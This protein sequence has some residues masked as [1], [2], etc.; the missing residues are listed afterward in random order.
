MGKK[1]VEDAIINVVINGEKAISSFREL[2]KLRKEQA[3]LVESLNKNSP[4]Y[5]Q[6][7][8]RLEDLNAAHK[9]WRAE[10]NNST[11]AIDRMNKEMGETGKN[12]FFD[13]MKNMFGKES[14][15]V[16]GGNLIA[17]GISTALNVVSSFVNGSE[18]AYVE[19][20]K[21]QAQLDA[22]LK[23]T[24]GVAGQTTESLADM[25]EAL[26]LQTGIDDDVISKGEQMLLTFTNVRGTIYEQALPAIV[27]M[28]AAMNQGTVTM[29]GI[30]SASIQVGKALNDPIKGMTA[31]SKVGVTFD[32]QQKEHIETLVKSNRIMDA[33]A[34]ILKELNKEFGGV[35]KGMADTDVGIGQKFETRMGNIQEIIG[36]WITQGKVFLIEFAEPVIAWIEKVIKFFDES[37][38]KTERFKK[39]ASDIGRLFGDL[40]KIIEPLGRAIGEAFT[41]TAALDVFRG[42]LLSIVIPLKTIALVISDIRK[43]E[44]GKAFVD[45]VQGMA[46][47]QKNVANTA[48]NTLILGKDIVV[49]VV[50][51][52]DEI[53]KNLEKLDKKGKEI[54]TKATGKGNKPLVVVVPPTTGELTEEQKLA[55]A[56]KA[57]QAREKAAK[58]L[59]QYRQNLKDAHAE[60]DK[61]MADSAKG[62]AK[63]LDAQ[64]QVI[65]DKYQK[66]IDRLKQLGNDKNATKEDKAYNKKAIKG[67]ETERDV[68]QEG[69]KRE[70]SYSAF[71]QG[72]NE[73][74]DNQLN[75]NKNALADQL[76]NEEEFAANEFEIE[77][78]RLTDLFDLRTLFGM[79]TLDLESKLADGRVKSEKRAFDAHME[80]LKKE[81]KTEE[82]YLETRRAIEAEKS[83]LAN[84]GLQLL[85]SVFG[86]SKGLM[87]AQLAVE[88]AIAISKIVQATGVEIAGYYAHP[89]SILSL[90][91][92][93]SILAAAAK[94]RAGLSIANIVASGLVEGIGISQSDSGKK[95]AKGG[96]LP[97]G[98]GH[99]EGGLK[100]V[101]PY[102]M[103]YGEVE[104]GEPILS[105]S[106]YANN[107]SLVDALLNSNGRQLNMERI[108][109]AT[110]SRERRMSNLPDTIN[111]ANATVRDE[112][113]SRST[114][115][116]NTI[117]DA[118]LKKMDIMAANM[119]DQKIVLS[120]RIFE[121][122]A[123][124][125]TQIRNDANA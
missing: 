89:A 94:V 98:P 102:G 44:F 100:L 36:K 52:T 48:K 90:G 93:G 125:N 108:S 67:L 113:A 70:E 118:L 26:M 28:T 31:L 123:T 59:A 15:M 97:D 110:T 83:V 73:G 80:Y 75:D 29:E 32:T 58:E 91:V 116:L 54:K 21:G 4:E 14:L 57:Q 77:Q 114:D 76:I 51:S 10:I 99:N 109:D 95:Y 20:V 38:E 84:T 56:K 40:W 53:A 92:S 24:Q 35:A 9:V 69:V 19:A 1:Q 87:F 61:F 22:A 111:R 49:G 81:Q 68:E 13:R 63:N 3:K 39:F 34:I 2:N 45:G 85:A 78:Q 17:N 55:A 65:N 8:R 47:F 120:N 50:K 25:A 62:T 105:R 33:Q 12:G 43:G 82:Q 96:L 30:Q 71:E 11:A 106:T 124:K 23:S 64:L 115:E 60:V 7:Q 66:L 88:K 46:E 107:R 117:F 86:K 5:A 37:N 101:D 79:Q 103:V 122:A 6:Q 119:G 74:A 18:A 104:G 72:V 42:M 41:K 121:K 16:A 112:T 27:D